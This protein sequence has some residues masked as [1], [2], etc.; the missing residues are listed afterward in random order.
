M[1]LTLVTASNCIAGLI[2]IH[3]LSLLAMLSILSVVELYQSGSEV[4]H[5]G[6][7]LMALLG[8]PCQWAVHAISLLIDC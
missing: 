6:H 2:V 3:E 4:S 5:P 8:C 7:C 1:C